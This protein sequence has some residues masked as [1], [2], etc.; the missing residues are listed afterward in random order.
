MQRRDPLGAS[1]MAA[2]AA[3]LLTK[4]VSSICIFKNSFL[5]VVEASLVF[6]VISSYW[7][8]AASCCFAAVCTVVRHGSGTLE[9][10]NFKGKT[11][12]MR[13]F[14]GNIYKILNF[15]PSIFLQMFLQKHLQ[16]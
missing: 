9:L 4:C 16:L 11:N 8:F 14:F 15:P 10:Y 13:P 1:G 7:V 6:Y 3:L 2:R 12:S 5:L